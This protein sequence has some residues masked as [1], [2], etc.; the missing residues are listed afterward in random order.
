MKKTISWKKVPQYTTNFDPYSEPPNYV[1][2]IRIKDFTYDKTEGNSL[3]ELNEKLRGEVLKFDLKNESKHYRSGSYDKHRLD[4][5]DYR[6]RQEFDSE[7]HFVRHMIDSKIE[8]RLANDYEFFPT[9]LE[10]E[11]VEE[12]EEEN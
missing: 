5:W 10:W 7:S 8:D 3:N 2:F 1:V 4:L 6:N 11:E 9:W 12:V